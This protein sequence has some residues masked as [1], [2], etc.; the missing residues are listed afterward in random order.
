[1]WIFWAIYAVVIIAALAAAFLIRPKTSG[2]P[3]APATIDDIDVPVAEEG[4]T[5]GVVFG[6]IDLKEFDV[7]WYGNF[8]ADPIKYSGGGKKK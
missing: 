7:V 1:M 4:K 8:L 6:T 2:P 3:I 5:V